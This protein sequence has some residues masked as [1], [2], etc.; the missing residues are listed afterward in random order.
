MGSG[1][2][3]NAQDLKPL[4]VCLTVRSETDIATQCAQELFS[5]FVLAIA[6][7]VASVGGRTEQR[8][9][10]TNPDSAVTER[11]LSNTVL[12][13][14][15]WQALRAKLAGNR[16]ET[17]ALVVPAFAHYGL[18]PVPGSRQD[19]FYDEPRTRTKQLHNELLLEAILGRLDQEAP[20]PS[21]CRSCL[22]S[23]I[24]SNPP[25]NESFRSDPFRATRKIWQRSRESRVGKEA[26]SK[27]WSERISEFVPT[28]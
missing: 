10:P 17:L 28:E 22:D 6:A 19:G 18:L 20:E 24:R 26:V 7:E 5:L 15:A 25:R 23:Q 9:V 14:I 16:N 4:P 11:T 27:P 12:D 8:K 2:Q 3:K 1:S 21:L 13:L